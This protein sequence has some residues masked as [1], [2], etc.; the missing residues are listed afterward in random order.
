MGENEELLDETDDPIVPRDIWYPTITNSLHALIDQY[1]EEFDFP[2]IQEEVPDVFQR[3]VKQFEALE[4]IGD[5]RGSIIESTYFGLLGLFSQAC[6]RRKGFD[7]LILDENGSVVAALL[8]DATV[9]PQEKSPLF[10]LFNPGCWLTVDESFYS[11]DGRPVY[12]HEE[13]GTLLE[14]SEAEQVEFID[15][16][17]Q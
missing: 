7:R 16:K 13:L 9:D 12:H 1:P 4:A 8:Y 17:L 6:C 11:P 14:M 2:K 10:R 5:A 3:I 15:S